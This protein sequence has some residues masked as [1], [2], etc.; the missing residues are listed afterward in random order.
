MNITQNGKMYQPQQLECRIEYSSADN[1]NGIGE[2]QMD[3]SKS[4]TSLTKLTPMLLSHGHASSDRNGKSHHMNWLWFTLGCLTGLAILPL[5]A[6]ASY[7]Y[8]VAKHGHGRPGPAPYQAEPPSFAPKSSN[9]CDIKA[10][11]RSTH[12]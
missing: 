5:C 1:S 7:Y 10:W 6:V 12:R 11:E 3:V 9:E 8:E 2:L 4:V